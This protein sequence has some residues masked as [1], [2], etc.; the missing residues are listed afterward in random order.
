M[1]RLPPLNA[2]KS[3]ESAARH[4]SFNKAAQELFVTPSAISHQIKTLESFLGLELFRRTKR[5]VILTEAGEEYIE[6]IK[7]VF[8]LIEMATNDV[9]SK[10]KQ[11]SLHLAVSPIFLNRW[12]MPRLGDFYAKHP[13]IELE[14][15]SSVGL[16][17]FDVADIDMAVYFGNGEWEDV[18]QHFLKPVILAPVCNPKIIKND[19][20]INTPEDMRFYPL[21]HVTK[22]KYE[23]HGWLEQNDLDPKLFRRGLMFSTGSLTAGAA[24][25]GLG[26]ALAD[27]DLIQP[28]VESGKLVVLFEQHLITNRSFYLVYQKRRSMTPAMKAFKNW[29]MQEIQP[30]PE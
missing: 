8:E 9:L 26:I 30:N 11:G 24:V 13:E 14:I 3:F 1:N 25:Q 27:P 21:L 10:Q 18:E 6:P 20:P 12:L 17:N 2:L 16:I 22:R 19:L 28:D 15:S 23:W 7:K 29:M 5:K 4:G